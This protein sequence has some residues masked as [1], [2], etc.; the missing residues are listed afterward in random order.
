MNMLILKA[1]SLAVAHE[2]V[3]PPMSYPARLLVND[4]HELSPYQD[5]P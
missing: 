2:D 4:P 1:S 5:R 3:E